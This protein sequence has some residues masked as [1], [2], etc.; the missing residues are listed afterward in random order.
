MSLEFE[1][2]STEVLKIFLCVI[3]RIYFFKNSKKKNIQN[4]K[5]ILIIV[6]IL[7]K[8]KKII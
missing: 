3:R 4:V 1:K 5:V 8:D 7:L 6:K 2:K